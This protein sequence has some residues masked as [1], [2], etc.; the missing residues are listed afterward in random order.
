MN[1]IKD[2]DANELSTIRIALLDKIDLIQGYIKIANEIH[3]PLA[4][5]Y[6]EETLDKHSR[7][8]NKL[9]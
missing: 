7:L 4:A 6:W 3:Q 1:N 9:Y 8:L 2:I 5:K